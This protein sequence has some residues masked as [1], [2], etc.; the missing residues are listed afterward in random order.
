MIYGVQF[1]QLIHY[2][3]VHFDLRHHLVVYVG[4]LFTVHDNEVVDLW[5]VSVE[6]VGGD[7]FR[8]LAFRGNCY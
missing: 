3:K 6:E 8:P 1:T 5:H 4:C 7:I 2:I